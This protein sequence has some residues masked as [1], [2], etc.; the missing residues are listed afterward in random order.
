M[1]APEDLREK[2]RRLLDSE[3]DTQGASPNE[4]AAEE[5]STPVVTPPTKGEK[6]MPLPRRVE[7][8]DVGATRV[9]P[10]AFENTPRRSVRRPASSRGVAVPRRQPF[11]WSKAGGCFVQGLIIFIFFIVG[12]GLVM[13]AVGIYEYY[14][15]A[16]GVC[17]P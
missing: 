5:G 4:E 1:T 12:L 7:E 2:F 3:A 6:A 10:S 8:I 11:N 9:T 13:A 17:P 14:S 16:S 15:I